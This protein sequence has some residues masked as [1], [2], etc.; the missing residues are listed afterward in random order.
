MPRLRVSFPIR[1]AN[2]RAIGT[3]GPSVYMMMQ[4]QTE[5]IDSEIEELLT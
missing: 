4:R 3:V 2:D 5:I 1:D